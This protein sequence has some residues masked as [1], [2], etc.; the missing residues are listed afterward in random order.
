MDYWI[1]VDHVGHTMVNLERLHLYVEMFHDVFLGRHKDDANVETAR[2]NLLVDIRWPEVPAALAYALSV[3]SMP[4]MTWDSDT[5]QREIAKLISK[6][7]MVAFGTSNHALIPS[8]FLQNCECLLAA[9]LQR[10]IRR[11]GGVAYY[12]E[13][14]MQRAYR[15]LIDVAEGLRSFVGLSYL[16]QSTGAHVLMS[17][18]ANAKSDILKAFYDPAATPPARVFAN[19]LAECILVDSNR[20]QVVESA[21]WFFAR[22]ERLRAFAAACTDTWSTLP[23]KIKSNIEVLVNEVCEATDPEEEPGLL[24]LASEFLA[25]DASP[26]ERE[27][28]A[29][30]AKKA[31][32]LTKETRSSIYKKSRP[33]LRLVRRLVSDAR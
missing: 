27:R 28:C 11:F 7:A 5:T 6:A 21:F 29:R 32:T 19:V 9:T 12:S 18:L 4:G 10:M 1:A 14:T 16:E 8:W 30:V 2:A 26:A 22:S 25:A 3:L 15:A 24:F 31:L 20:E 33:F 23:P 17:A 13:E